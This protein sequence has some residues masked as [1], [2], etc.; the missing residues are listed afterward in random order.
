MLELGSC[1]ADP[2]QQ[3]VAFLAAVARCTC[4]CCDLLARLHARLGAAMLCSGPRRHLRVASHIGSCSCS[5]F[6]WV[7]VMRVPELLLC[8]AVAL[9]GTSGVHHTAA[10]AML[11]PALVGSMCVPELLLCSAVAFYGILGLLALWANKFDW[12]SDPTGSTI[13]FSIL[14]GNVSLPLTCIPE[15]LSVAILAQCSSAVLICSAA[16]VCSMHALLLQ[17]LLP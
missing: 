1:H 8:R 13:L 17:S 14:D 11:C 2:K 6:P 16:Q 4:C 12:D 3:L 15:A 5:A 10:V 9:Y 7:G